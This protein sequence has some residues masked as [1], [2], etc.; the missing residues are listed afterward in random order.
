V[1]STVE[2]EHHLVGDHGG[3]V[4]GPQHGVHQL[5]LIHNPI[6]V[7]VHLCE[8][9]ISKLLWSIPLFLL[10]VRYQ[11][12]QMLHN[13]DQLTLGNETPL[14]T[15]KSSKNPNQWPDISTQPT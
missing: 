5:S 10:S 4:L 8:K 11:V 12:E 14:L 6:L 3:Q 7:Q 9:V 15:I 13:L 1:A 2:P